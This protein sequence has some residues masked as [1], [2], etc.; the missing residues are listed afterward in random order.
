MLITSY[1]YLIGSSIYSCACLM[2]QQLDLL[3][4]WVKSM[5]LKFLNGTMNRN[6]NEF[7]HRYK[8]SL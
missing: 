8:P 4:D 1:R 5:V 7:R 6:Q 2:V 3:I